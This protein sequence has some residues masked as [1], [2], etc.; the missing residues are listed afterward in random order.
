[1]TVAKTGTGLGTVTSSPAGISCGATCSAKFT[2]G[3]SVT[4]AATPNSGS[5]F[6]GWSGDCVGATCRLSMTTDHN[7]TA[8]FARIVRCVVPRL[9]GLKLRTA[10]AK[11]ARAHCHVGKI[12]RR[13]SSLRKKGKV[14]AQKPRA[15]RRLTVGARVNLVVGKGPRRR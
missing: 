3:A 15:G 7:A 5:R 14:L 2:L 9:I 4:L 11:I 13:F 6:V 8:K 12:T 10:R 1:L